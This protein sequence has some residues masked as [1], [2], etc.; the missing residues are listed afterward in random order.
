MTD[1]DTAVVSIFRAP[2]VAICE[3]SVSDVK[4]ARSLPLRATRPV[5]TE[6]GKL[7]SVLLSVSACRRR[8][9][10]G[11][12]KL[13]RGEG[14]R[15]PLPRLSP[16]TPRRREEDEKENYSKVK[17]FRSNLLHLPRYGR[18]SELPRAVSDGQ[19]I[20]TPLCSNL[21]NPPPH[22]DGITT[23]TEVEIP[24]TV[25]AVSLTSSGSG[26]TAALCP[27]AATNGSCRRRDCNKN[28][29]GKLRRIRKRFGKERI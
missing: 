12:T 18:I 22:Y 15:S 2:G 24:R 20:Q 23:S 8:R 3:N 28:R 6:Q 13:P 17:P 27:A 11:E 1:R 4:F 10:G 9:G 5:T 7:H 21:L 14:S 25:S 19:I 29:G 16:T 26:D